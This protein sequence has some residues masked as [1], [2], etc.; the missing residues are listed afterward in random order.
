MTAARH[1]DE[2]LTAMATAS[3]A[4]GRHAEP[5]PGWPSDVPAVA[6]G[7]PGRAAALVTA[8]PDSAVPFHPD[9]V[10]DGV[11]VSG[12]TGT[13]RLDLRAASVR[14]LSHRYYGRVRQDDYAFVVTGDSRYLVLAVADGVSAGALSHVA[15]GIVTRHG[16]RRI[17]GQLTNCEPD[18]LDWTAILCG[19]ADDVVSRAGATDPDLRDGDA[20]TVAERMAATVLFAVVGTDPGADGAHPVYAMAYGDTSAWLLDPAAQPPWSPLHAV[21]NAGAGLASSATFAVPLV[22]ATAPPP[23]RT[24]LAPGCALVLMTDGVGDPLG[25]GGGDVGTYLAAAWTQP[26][27]PLTFAAQIGFAR[28]S[29]DDDR[30]VVAVWPAAGAS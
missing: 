16:C 26:P 13:D 14:G 8:R 28:R 19:V 21:K 11:R 25:G 1:D 5:D 30:T 2:V 9:T 18:D 10:L 24:H 4:H 12:A 22:P 20:P 29:Y 3:P 6:V 17:A 7:E 23:V 15:A 27:D